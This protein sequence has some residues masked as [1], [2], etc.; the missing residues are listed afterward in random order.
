M[1]VLVTDPGAVE[2]Q[3]GRYHPES[4]RR[5]DAVMK[6]VRNPLVRDGLLIAAPRAARPLELAKVHDEALLDNL[7]NIRGKYAQIDGD[8]AVSP[9][10]VDVAVK[11]AGSGLTALELLDS[12]G[13]T[14]AFCA[15][16]PPGHHATRHQSMG[17]CL[18]NNVAVTAAALRER[19]ER[20]VIVDYDVHHGNGT[21]DIF[22]DDPNVLYVSWHQSPLFPNTG[23]IGETGGPTAVGRTINVPLPPTMTGPVYFETL[24]KVIGPLIERFEPTW[25]LISAGFDAHRND[26][27]SEMGLTSGD[28]AILT[29]T[30]MQSVPTGRTIAFLEGGYNLDALT[31]CAEATIAAMLGITHHPE[32][33]SHVHDFDPHDLIRMI[34]F[35]QGLR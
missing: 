9:E 14:A 25:L 4:P 28:Y 27:L 3:T 30:L 32:T 20:V 10:S 21:Q 6:A 18:L 2:H 24:D 8:T 23:R 5:Y 33:P 29:A 13:A 17:F 12:G 22:Y 19:G 16:R 15:V 31:L 34:E 26:P 35:A 11:A 7:E 1:L